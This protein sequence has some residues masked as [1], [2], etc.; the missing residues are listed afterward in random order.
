LP[1]APSLGGGKCPDF[2]EE[3][4]L[5][6]AGAELTPVASMRLHGAS[7]SL[8]LRAHASVPCQLCAENCRR[9]RPISAVRVVGDR[10]CLRP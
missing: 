8:A 1:R 9:R 10:A 5:S 7:A 3:E 2:V 4:Q 6:V